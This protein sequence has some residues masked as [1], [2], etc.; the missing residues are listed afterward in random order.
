MSDLLNGKT[1]LIADGSTPVGRVASALFT[2]RGAR[3]IACMPGDVDF[4]DET[5]VEVLADR[6]LQEGADLTG[7]FY[8]IIPDVPA[9]RIP[10]L[11]ESDLNT[12]IDR[13]ITAAFNVSRV[14]GEYF[15]RREEMA[16]HVR[17]FDSRAIVFLGSIHDE[18][19]N[20]SRPLLSF[21]MGA[22]QNLVRECALHYG[23]WGVRTNVIELGATGGED[24]F[25]QSDISGFYQGYSYKIPDGRVGTPEDAAEIAAFLL[26]PASRYINGTGLRADGGLT[27]HY[28][29]ANANSREFRRREAAGEPLGTEQREVPDRNRYVHPDTARDLTDGG[30]PEAG[31]PL[32][33]RRVLVTGSGKGIGSDI[34]LTSAKLG[35]SVVVHY[36]SSEEN[37]RKVFAEAQKICR[38]NNEKLAALRGASSAPD[39]QRFPDGQRCVLIR[40]N[41]LSDG[42]PE[43]LFHAAEEAL[44]GID[45]LVNNAAMQI[46]FSYDQYRAEQLR[47]LFR[48]NLRGYTMMSRLALPGMQERG[49]GR[50]VNISSVHSKRPTTFDPVYCMT[51][52]GIRMLTRE[53]ALE[54]LTADV[55]VNAVEPGAVEIGVK[56]GNPQATVPAKNLIWPPL[57]RYRPLVGGLLDPS[58]ISAAVMFFLS[59]A[60]GR[61]NGSCLRVG[62][63]LVLR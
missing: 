60:A 40:E 27:L 57:F 21:Y 19:P 10:D 32:Y 61:I 59:E 14:F 46:N 11:S 35:A 7:V 55:T 5:A 47:R 31:L 26:S 52:G 62:D 15:R 44:G 51:K 17:S 22:L 53:L 28:I 48:V 13:D 12:L 37:A 29:D 43:L 20:G 2:E 39:L 54:A 24:E 4:G 45:I 18:K 1:I 16:G 23:Q 34:M 56:S 9:R 33:G 42:G 3:V 50:I 8:N 36:N 41:L 38:G 30:L 63:G 6:L 58:E 49:W 25:F